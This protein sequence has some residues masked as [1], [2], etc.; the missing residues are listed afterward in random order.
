MDERIEL[1]IAVLF[2]VGFL[3]VKGW[4]ADM[5][6][7]VTI[8]PVAVVENVT[9]I[10]PATTE[11]TPEPTESL[12][13]FM[14]R[15]NGYH[16]RD[17]HFWFRENANNFGEN[18]RTWATVY[19]YLVLPNYHYWS[20]SWGRKLKE[21]PSPGMKYLFVFVNT[22]S[23]GDDARQH[24]IEPH[25][26]YVQINTT[27]YR[28]EET[29]DPTLRI[30]E[31]DNLWNFAHVETPQ[32]YPY[33]IVQEAGTG[34]RTAIKADVIYSGRSNAVDGYLIYEVPADTDIKDVKVV[35]NFANLGGNAWWLLE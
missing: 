24:I 27:L 34:I 2:I 15:T 22:Y 23:D 4:Y 6:R 9:N 14:A 3:F 8:E 12:E 1:L 33:K 18:L 10:T 25:N 35:G 30:T 16:I 29:I 31:L 20:V 7:P 26:W 5:H 13:E 17:W 21:T 32:P 11:P 28:P 19:D